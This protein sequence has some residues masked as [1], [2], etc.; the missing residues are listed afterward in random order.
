VKLATVLI[1][2]KDEAASI[3]RTLDLLAEQD[4]A[5][6]LETVVVDSGSKDAT[7]SIARAAHAHVVEIPEESFTF[8]RALNR[9]CE[10]AGS[11][12][13]IALS[14]H[15]F[16]RD[17]RWA[18]RMIGALADDRVACATGYGVDPNGLPLTG[19]RVQ[20][21]DDLRQ[22]PLW[23][24]SNACGAFRRPLWQQRPFREDMPGPE[25]K[26]WAAHWVSRGY[27]AV[28]DPA[29]SVDHS[30]H[31]DGPLLT[32]QRSRREWEGFAMYLDLRPYPL[33]QLVRDWWQV[34]GGDRRANWRRTAALAGEWRGCRRGRVR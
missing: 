23:G 5:E 31:H 7:V 16:P 10:E 15:A 3:G 24:Y 2:A 27:L 17:Q 14:A 12:I 29:L 20:D 8:G 26:E 32:F 19:P 33:A 22:Y 18:R 9:G 6:S 28:V 30:H 1:R 4:V 25:D 34:D 11:D 13:V 21:A